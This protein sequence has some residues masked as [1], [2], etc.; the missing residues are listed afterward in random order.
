LSGV[1]SLIAPILWTQN[2]R[3]KKS[4]SC[5][6]VL[7]RKYREAANNNLWGLTGVQKKRVVG[8]V[9]CKGGGLIARLFEMS[10]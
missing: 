8:I 10:C 5:E 7:A 9:E 2:Q 1:F 3:K 4:Q 6:G